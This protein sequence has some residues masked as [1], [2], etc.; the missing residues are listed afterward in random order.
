MSD[1]HSTINCPATESV[2]HEFFRHHPR[3]DKLRHSTKGETIRHSR[4][5][6]PHHHLSPFRLLRL[7]QPRFKPQLCGRGIA[8][9]GW[10][11]ALGRIDVANKIL[12]ELTKLQRGRLSKVGI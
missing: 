5:F 1:R 11:A 10:N 7:N 4:S 3:A 9:V 8:Q 6:P 12:A 2:R